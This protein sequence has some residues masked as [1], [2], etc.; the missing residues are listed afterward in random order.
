MHAHGAVSVTAAAWGAVILLLESHRATTL[1]QRTPDVPQ[2]AFT[3]QS[4]TGPALISL[5]A[6]SMLGLE[7]SGTQTQS[8]DQVK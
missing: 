7:I 1:S 8:S 2:P 6:G 4:S 5:F 3:C